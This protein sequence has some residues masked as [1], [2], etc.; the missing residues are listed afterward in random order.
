[1]TRFGATAEVERGTQRNSGPAI[2]GFRPYLDV[3]CQRIDQQHVIEESVKVSRL[4]A[5][6]RWTLSYNLKHGGS[7]W[8]RVW[9]RFF[10]ASICHLETAGLPRKLPA[11]QHVFADGWIT[12]SACISTRDWNR[13]RRRFCISSAVPRTKFFI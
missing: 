9:K 11:E 1:M 4:H 6:P 3:R 2:C 5:A 13:C 12:S 10:D 8:T 7:F